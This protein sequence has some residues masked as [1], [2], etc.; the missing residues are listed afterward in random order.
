MLESKGTAAWLRTG[1]ASPVTGVGRGGACG[2]GRPHQELRRPLSGAGPAPDPHQP[3]QDNPGD[4]RET[5][6]Q[7]GHTH[8]FWG[9]SCE[10]QEKNVLPRTLMPQPLELGMVSPYTAKGTLQRRQDL[11][12]GTRSWALWLGLMCDHGGQRGSRAGGSRGRR[13]DGRWKMLC[14][15][16]RRGRKGQDECS[17]G[18]DSWDRRG[19][20]REEPALPTHQLQP[21]DT[22]L[23][24]PTEFGAC[25]AAATRN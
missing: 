22:D 14:G 12:M 15:W 18:P 21:T 25:V 5:E 1:E 16:L 23:W 17:R 13:G 3:V 2:E 8:S 7:E 20:L 24:P 6:A 9:A 19:R 11:E 10:G 4:R